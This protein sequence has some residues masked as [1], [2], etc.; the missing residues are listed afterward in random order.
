MRSDVRD[1]KGASAGWL[2]KSRRVDQQLLRFVVAGGVTAVLDMALLYLLT[3]KV[4]LHYLVSVALAFLVA[5]AASYVLNVTWVF[6]RGRHRPE[7][8]V[9]VFFL[10]ST[11]GL[12]LNE[13]IVFTLVEGFF[14]WYLAAKV[15]AIAGAAV[16]NF[17][18]RRRFVFAS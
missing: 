6:W 3:E 11:G 15:V 14:V 5:A 8:E 17:W 16:W 4:H 2:V 10:T 9:L 13:L 1:R 7:V 12:V 18:C